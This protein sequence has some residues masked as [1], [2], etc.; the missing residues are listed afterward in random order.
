[1]SLVR[2]CL[3]CGRFV[4]DDHKDG[5]STLTERHDH[6]DQPRVYRAHLSCMNLKHQQLNSGFSSAPESAVLH[7]VYRGQKRRDLVFGPIVK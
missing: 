7:P 6:L 4:D 3:V 1:M 5:A 2:T